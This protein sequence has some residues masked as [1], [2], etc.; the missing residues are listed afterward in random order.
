M[1]YYSYDTSRDL[2]LCGEGADV[3]FIVFPPTADR[4]PVNWFFD[5]TCIP[6][7]Q[8]EDLTVGGHAPVDI[9]INFLIFKNLRVLQI[10]LEQVHWIEE[11]LGLLHPQSGARIPCQSLQEIRY[12]CR[13]SLGP[14]VGLVKERERAGYQLGLV[15]LSDTHGPGGHLA[16]ELNLVEE[17]KE[18]VGEVRVGG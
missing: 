7:G 3:S 18:H 12:A 15:W 13:G 16:E 2:R 4:A 8:I 9:P 14:L 17:L 5:E 1:L 11:F 10:T 6:F